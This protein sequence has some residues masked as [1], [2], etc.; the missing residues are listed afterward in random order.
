MA[1]A[2]K[3]VG[4]DTLRIAYPKINQIIDKV[5]DYQGQIDQLVIE[6]DSSVEAAQ[7]RVDK[8][9]K[10]YTTL[11][12]RLDWY[13]E[14]FDVRGVNVKK[15]GAIGDGLID[16]T[17]AI[18]NALNAENIVIIPKGDFKVKDLTLKTGQQLLIS[19]NL[20]YDPAS[21][22]SMIT[23]SSLD[24]V[25]IY[26]FGGTLNGNGNDTATSITLAGCT[27]SIVKGLRIKTFLNKGISLNNCDGVIVSENNV[28]GGSGTSGAGISVFGATCYRCTV[29]N[30]VVDGNRIGISV[31]GGGYHTINS[32]TC[33]ANALSGIMLDG[34][35]TGSGDGTKHST[36]KG[37]VITNCSNSGYGGIYLGNGSSYN[38]ISNNISSKN[39][40]SGIRFSAGSGFALYGNILSNNI[41]RENS[42]HGVEMSYGYQTIIAG[43]SIYNNT[44]RGIVGSYSDNCKISDNIIRGNTQQGIFWQSGNTSINDNQATGNDKGIE[45]AYGGSSPNNNVITGNDLSG[46]T[47]SNLTVV[48]INKIENN[49][50]YVNENRG[51]ATS[52]ANGGTIPHGLAGNPSVTPYGFA[53]VQAKGTSNA[54]PSNIRVNT[55]ATNITVYYQGT[56]PFDFYWTASLGSII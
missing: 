49:I 25:G 47:T 4:T 33:D 51:I 24:G 2:P 48:D 40:R 1:D 37:N 53:S 41:L 45:L 20:N 13:D 43:N 31:N 21:S 19:G 44:Q 54:G 56:G 3:L 32:N 39:A 50:G 14:E 16:D 15:Y 38:D 29:T 35:V 12:A 34:I 42:Y 10:T 7:A 6:G 55:D 5:N 46:N 9:G 18:Q 11:K 26:G 17:I 27:N 23:A 52:L 28:S 36:V 22:G 30:N 8:D